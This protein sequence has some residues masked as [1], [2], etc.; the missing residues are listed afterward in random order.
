MRRAALLLTVLVLAACGDDEVVS[1]VPVGAPVGEPA[2][3]GFE[4]HGDTARDLETGLIWDRFVELGAATAEQADAACATKGARLPTRQELLALRRPGAESGDACQLPACP[5]R[6]DRCATL[7]CGSA[8]PGTDAR[9]GV[10]FSGGALVMV[11]AGQAE[12][13]VCVR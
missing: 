6:G 10:A 9:W 3:E 1:P 2:C 5:F 11:P 12:A 4:L 13:M 7:Q 8:V